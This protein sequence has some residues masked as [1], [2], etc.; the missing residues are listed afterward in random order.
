MIN[1]KNLKMYKQSHNITLEI[2]KVTLKYL[3]SELFA[4]VNQMR[5]AAYSAPSNIV[6]GASRK[7]KNDTL[8]FFNIALASAEELRYFLLLSKDL[9]YITVQQ[10]QK[11]SKELYKNIKMIQK[12]I[13][14]S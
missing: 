5:R 14:N 13:S 10:H 12:F 8:K 4:I 7:S 9:D 6:E 11:I 3:K 2:Y 1:Y